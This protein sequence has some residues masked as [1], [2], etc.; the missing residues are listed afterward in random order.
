MT[1]KNT[2]QYKHYDPEQFEDEVELITYLRVIWKRK[3]FIILMVVLCSLAA[4]GYTII[5][6]PPKYVTECI[7]ELNFRGI[8]K[9]QN[10]DHSKSRSHHLGPTGQYPQADKIP[11]Y[12][13]SPSQTLSWSHLPLFRL[14]SSNP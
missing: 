14:P 7:V 8:E 11:S 1:D 9:G 6:Y 5:K 10:P 2:R 12:S 4:A 3:V 13:P